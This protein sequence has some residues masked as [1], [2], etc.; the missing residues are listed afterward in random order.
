MRSILTFALLIGVL[1]AAPRLALAND[2]PSAGKPAG[3]GRSE[4]PTG[5]AGG[6]T[7]GGGGSAMSCRTPAECLPLNVT[8]PA[9]REHGARQSS[10][11]S[12]SEFARQ[13]GSRGGFGSLGVAGGPRDEHRPEIFRP[14]TL[15]PPTPL[16]A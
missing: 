9:E 10:R 6:G 13:A 7:G 15:R 5:G 8:P 2:G 3:A 4:P 1:T 12:V 14:P 16:S 11:A